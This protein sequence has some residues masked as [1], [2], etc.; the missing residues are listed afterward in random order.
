MALEISAAAPAR[1]SYRLV[2]RPPGTFRN[3]PHPDEASGGPPPGHPAHAGGGAAGMR[4]RRDPELPV[5]D[6]TEEIRAKIGHVIFPRSDSGYTVLSIKVDGGRDTTLQVVT[7]VSVSAGDRIVARGKWATYKGKVQF[8]ADLIQLEIPRETRGIVAWISSDG[9][10]EGVGRATGLK[11]A[12]HFGDL[13]P[14]VMHDPALLQQARIGAKKAAAIAKAWNNNEAQPELVTLL[15]GFG[16]GPKT[17]AKVIETYGA[18]IKKVLARDPWQLVEIEGI[19]FPTADMIAMKGGLDMACESRVQRGLEWAMTEILNREGHCCLPPARLVHKAAGSKMLN[20]DRRILE[21]ALEKFVDGVRVVSDPET[22]YLFPRLLWDAERDTAEAMASLVLNWN[23]RLSRADAKEAVAHAEVE[24]GVEL[25]RDGGQFEAA[26]ASLL[27]PVVVITGG[28]GTGKS[29]TQKVVVKAKENLGRRVALSAPTGRAAKRLSETSGKEAR[30]NHRLLEFSP[31]L[32]D[33]VH[34]RVNRLKIDDLIVDETSMV[35]IRMFCAVV[36]AL[37]DTGGL[38]LVGDADQLPSVSGGQVLRDLIESGTVPVLYLTRVHRQAAGS[39]VAIAA[40]RIKAGEF[41]VAR[42]ETLRGFRISERDDM[43]ILAEV[44]RLVRSEIPERGFDPMRDVQV[45]A[46]VRK[47]ENGVDAL[48]MALKDALNP[49]LADGRS[50]KLMANEFTVGDRVM[51]TRNDYAKGVY[52]GEV[53]SITAVGNDVDDKGRRYSWVAA[54]F[55]GAEA[56]YKPEEAGDLELAYASTVHRGQ[57]CE[58]PVV[59]MVAAGDNADFLTRN[60]V[61]T[62]ITR[63]RMECVVVGSVAAVDRAVRVTERAGR[64]TGLRRRLEES[65]PLMADAA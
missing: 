17:V 12:A 22:G 29:T 20:L 37:P 10:V 64:H 52:N 31:K 16:L 8:K 59:I 46:P 55:A 53:G 25:D 21:E 1:P 5:P 45:L 4:A 26:V 62:G 48:N 32:G 57:G 38:V 54:D 9:A 27:H 15:M 44:V 13:L 56:R 19:G 7:T 34:N 51:Q 40:K 39:G 6:E 3:A 2:A 49:V 35:D 18:S 58:F 63:A 36:T 43:D 33:F 23:G 28:P 30:T 11:L 24:L 14:G 47:R 42:G 61:Y 65:V 41:P 60:L 50:V